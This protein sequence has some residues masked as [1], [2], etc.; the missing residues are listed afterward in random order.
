M[1]TVE[2]EKKAKKPRAVKK[3]GAGTKSVAEKDGRSQ[4]RN[5]CC[6]AGRKGGGSAQKSA[7]KAYA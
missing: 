7:C 3:T 6:K 2:E 5:A 4:G 1:A